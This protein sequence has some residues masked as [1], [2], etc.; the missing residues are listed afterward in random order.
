VGREVWDSRIMVPFSAMLDQDGMAACDLPEKNPLK[1]FASAG[2]LN[3][4]YRE[5]RQ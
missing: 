3:P 2:K 1:Y 5:D 4:S